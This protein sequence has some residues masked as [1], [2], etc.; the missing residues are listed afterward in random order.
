MHEMP[1]FPV[2]SGKNAQTA[3]LQPGPIDDDR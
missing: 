2:M 3:I 1:N